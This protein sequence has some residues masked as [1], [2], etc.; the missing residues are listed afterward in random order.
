MIRRSL[1]AARLRGD[2]YFDWRGTDITRMEALTDAVFGFAM[3]LLIV[4]LDVPQSFEELRDA[5][6]LMPAF[7]VTFAALIMFWYYHYLFC[8]RYGMEDLGTQ[9]LNA[10]LLFMILFYVYPL[11][12]LATLMLGPMMGHDTRVAG[13][14]G[15]LRSPLQAGE[16]VELMVLYGGGF[17]GIFFLYFLLYFRA[18]SRRELLGLNLPER[19]ITAAN[20]RAHLIMVSFGLISCAICLVAP[21]RTGLAGLVYAGIGPTMFIHASLSYRRLGSPTESQ[22][23]GA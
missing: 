8:R 17:C 23:A 14:D 6:R 16:N 10:M 15:A 21:G 7:A 18:W 9:I 13:P 5:F 11:K 12:F 19:I 4:S 3:T 2:V 1:Q 20:M 22:D